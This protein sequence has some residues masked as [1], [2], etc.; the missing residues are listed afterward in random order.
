MRRRLTP[1]AT[2]L[3][4]H[5]IPQLVIDGVLVA[6]AYF[7]AYRLRFDSG[8]PSRYADLRGTTLPWVVPL[9]IVVFALFGL[10]AAADV[11]RVFGAP[12]HVR[13]LRAEAQAQRITIALPSAPGPM[14][15]R[16]VR[17]GRE[18]G[19]AAGTLPTGFAHLQGSG[20]VMRQVRE[21][22]V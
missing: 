1:K 21:V 9:R 19:S 20:A 18:R 6:A 15:A 4:R 7:L 16:I 5:S 8:I 14:R 10:V 3:H 11:E 17:A 12:V 22:Q 2:P 13:A